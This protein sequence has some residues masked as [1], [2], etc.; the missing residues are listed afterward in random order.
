[1]PDTCLIRFS[2]LGVRFCV[3]LVFLFLEGGG[4]LMAE[5]SLAQKLELGASDLR[6]LLTN[7]GI[8]D[9]H[10]GALFYAGVD[11]MLSS[12]LS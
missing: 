10:Q 9:D 5:P 12:R 4:C 11:T 8:K 7:H 1:M 6:F 2:R 3:K